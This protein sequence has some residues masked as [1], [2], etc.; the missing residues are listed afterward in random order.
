MLLVPERQAVEA[1]QSSKTTIFWK[2]RGFVWEGIFT[3]KNVRR[4]N[5]LRRP[6]ELRLFFYYVWN[7]CCMY[8]D[9]IKRT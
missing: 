9:I 4:G 6:V 3:F 8:Q 2:S 1:S 7:A 5:P